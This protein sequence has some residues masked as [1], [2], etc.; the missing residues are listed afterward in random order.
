MVSYPEDTYLLSKGASLS[1]SINSSLAQK[2]EIFTLEDGSSTGLMMTVS[3]SA[4]RAQAIEQGKAASSPEVH[5]SLKIDLIPE[6]I[7]SVACRLVI[8]DTIS[9][10]LNNSQLIYDT[11]TSS[12]IIVTSVTDAIVAAFDAVRFL[13]KD[14]GEICLFLR[15]TYIQLVKA[16]K[17]L[18]EVVAED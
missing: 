1:E 18:K 15:F 4:S 12:L 6:E 16:I 17:A 8:G 2:L 14:K 10:F 9:F 5:L 11:W 3:D 13:S 7:R